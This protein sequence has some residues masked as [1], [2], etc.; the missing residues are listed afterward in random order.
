[1]QHYML[2]LGIYLMLGN[3]LSIEQLHIKTS[4]HLSSN[5][6]MK[7]ILL[8]LSVII[9]SGSLWAKHGHFC[10]FINHL[11]FFILQ[12]DTAFPLWRCKWQTHFDKHS[13]PSL[14]IFF[15]SVF[16]MNDGTRWSQCSEV[17][18]HGCENDQLPIDTEIL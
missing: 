11:H 14:N 12:L 5:S 15:V 9:T 7:T 13:S 17:E 6:I 2:V 18:D 1:M 10:L 4:A 16:N 8:W 3:F